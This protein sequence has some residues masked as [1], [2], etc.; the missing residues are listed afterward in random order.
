[1]KP[2]NMSCNTRKSQPIKGA[3]CTSES[4]TPYSVLKNSI[5]QYLMLYYSPTPIWCWIDAALYKKKC[6]KKWDLVDKPKCQL[7]L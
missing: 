2:Y 4:L 5:T 1:M 6:C 3:I 7:S